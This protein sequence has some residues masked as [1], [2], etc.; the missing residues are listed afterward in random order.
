MSINKTFSWTKTTLSTA[1]GAR[2]LHLAF[3]VSPAEDKSLSD[4]ARIATQ[5]SE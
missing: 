3:I 1:D 4:G 2:E 5:I